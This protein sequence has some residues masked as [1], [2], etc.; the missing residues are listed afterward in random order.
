MYIFLLVASIVVFGAVCIVYVR[1][2][3][4]SWFHPLTLYLVFHGL[5]FVLRAWMGYYFEYDLIYRGY[6][7]TPDAYA[8]NMALVVTNLGLVAFAAAV[9]WVGKTPLRLEDN[10]AGDRREQALPS[11]LL[12]SIFLV[13]AFA[14]AIYI[15]WTFRMTN[16]ELVLFDPVTG[17]RTLT[18]TNGYT[19]GMFNVAVFLLP[20]FAWLFRFRPWAL[21]LLAITFFLLQG[22]GTRGPTIAALFCLACFYLYD[23][24][25]LWFDWRVMAL[26]VP[27][28]MIFT[29][30][31]EDR[32]KA[33]REF[34]V[35][36][37]STVWENKN[38][39]KPLEGMDF[40]NLEMIEFLT[41]TVPRKTGTHEYFVDQLQIFTEP[42]PRAL[43]KDKPYGQ[44]IRLF[45]LFRYG[46]PIGMTRSLP[47]EGWTQLGLIG[48]VLWCGLWGIA[49]GKFYEWFVRNPKT[50]F[51]LA[52]Y[53]CMFSL[54]I[55][56]Y[57]DGLL[58]S[59]MRYGLFVIGPI[60][61]WK[62]VSVAFS[63]SAARGEASGAYRP[64]R[65]P[66]GGPAAAGRG[67]PARSLVPRAWRTR[68]PAE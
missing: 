52:A 3:A 42:I 68:S 17:V 49:L 1:H 27:V 51:R 64:P 46:T 63:E 50:P 65:G 9:L 8:K 47:G 4:A 5:S 30:V 13:P 7:F 36:D 40:G 58:L 61:A 67:E 21:V 62:A 35:T 2:P 32:G 33:I 10:V 53:F 18:E 19:M 28:F 39:D 48:V 41:N 22:I 44:P 45:Y 66:V 12:L 59:V 24:R 38:Y 25:R 57:R 11:F 16:K 29:A 6:H 23:K 54:M 55:V 15:G 56:C 37:T 60:L 34:F 31:G 20:V 43:W 14:Y 26:V